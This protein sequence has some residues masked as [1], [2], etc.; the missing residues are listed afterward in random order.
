MT[1]AHGLDAP[2]VREQPDAA[3]L[4]EAPEDRVGRRAAAWW[5]AWCAL[6]YGCTREPTHMHQFDD[7]KW[8]HQIKPNIE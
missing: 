3:L 7:T 6:Q 4:H 5:S 2:A 8:S 1:A